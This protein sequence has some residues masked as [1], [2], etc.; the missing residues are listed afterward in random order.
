MDQRTPKNP[1]DP[2]E[3]GESA[4]RRKRG[5]VRFVPGGMK[6]VVIG[7]A[8]ILV[9]LLVW[10]IQP[11]SNAGR[12]WNNPFFAGRNQRHPRG[13]DRRGHSRRYP[14]LR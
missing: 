14:C 9:A 6:T 12:P 2:L 3:T 8:V 7:A 5:W 11:A 10:Y 1:F 4:V 13:R